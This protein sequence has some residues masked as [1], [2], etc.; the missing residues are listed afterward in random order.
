MLNLAKRW[1]DKIWEFYQKNPKEFIEK[2]FD[3]D[4]HV[5]KV[6]ADLLEY[7]SFEKRFGF[8][9]KKIGDYDYMDAKLRIIYD[10]EDKQLDRKKKIQFWVYTNDLGNSK[11][12]RQAN[13]LLAKDIIEEWE[14]AGLPVYK[15]FGNLS[16]EE[17]Q[18][19]LEIAKDE[20]K[21]KE[22]LE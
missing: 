1:G 20:K 18:E 11:K 16:E 17:K 7:G 8:K 14:K 5:E 10:M 6:K 15:K 19:I 13:Y 22:F 2:Y 9:T 4:M 21:L 3:K 12:N